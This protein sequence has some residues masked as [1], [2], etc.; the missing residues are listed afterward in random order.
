MCNKPDFD[1]AQNEATKLLLRQNLSSLFFDIRAF[2][3]DRKIHIDSVQNYARVL[4]RPVSDFTCDEF[5]GCCLIPHPR[6]NLVLYDDEETDERRKHWG[7]VHEVGHVYM[8]HEEDGE[9]EEIEAHF[10]A[11]QLVAPEIIL[12]EMCRKKGKLYEIDLFNHFNIS[13]KAAAKR[14]KTLERRC[15]YNNAVIDQ[16]LLSKLSHILDI[17]L[18]HGSPGFPFSWTSEIGG[19]RRE[20]VA[21]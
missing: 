21:Y 12:W 2:N 10:F 11:A 4:G 17:E 18:A 14:I 13:H 5:S 8:D 9:K 1:R 3:F 7:I 15:C 6:C 19:P 16:Q 20:S